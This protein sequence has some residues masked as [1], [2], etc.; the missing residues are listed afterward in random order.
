M[1]KI[2]ISATVQRVKRKQI[3]EY[4]QNLHTIS[5]NDKIQN[6]SNTTT[7]ISGVHSFSHKFLNDNHRL[8]VKKQ[9]TNAWLDEKGLTNDYH[10]SLK[11]K[12]KKNCSIQRILVAT[13]LTV[14]IC[15][16]IT[17]VL[18]YIL[19]KS[20]KQTKPAS[21]F[22]PIL[23]WNS[24]GITVAGI[25]NTPGNASNL[26][27][28]PT[29]IVLIHPNLLYI[30]DY[31]NH[32]IQKYQLGNSNGTTVAD[33]AYGS[34]GSLSNQLKNPSCIHIDSSN[35]IYISDS[36]NNRVQYWGNNMLTGITVAGN[37]A[38]MSDS[39]NDT[40][41]DPVGL[42]RNETTG[43][44]YI[45]D[46]GNNRVM[47]YLL[48]ASSG[49]LAA[50]T[51][52]FGTGPTRDRRD[53]RFVPSR[54]RT[55]RDEKFKT[56]RGTGQS[57]I[58]TCPAI[59]LF[60]CLNIDMDNDIIFVD[61]NQN[62]SFSTDIHTSTENSPSTSSRNSL[63]IL[64]WS[65]SNQSNEYTC[66]KIEML[67]K[68]NGKQYIVVDNTKVHSSKC[69]DLFGFPAI[70]ESDGETPKII[71]KFVTCR[72]CYMTY[73]FNSNST[74]LLNNHICK[75]PHRARSSSASMAPNSS[76]S[77]H[78]TTLASYTAA[79]GVKLSD[80]HMKR[81]KDLQANWI[82][83]DIRPFAIIEDDGFREIA[84]E[85]VSLGAKYGNIEVGRVLR[86]SKIIG[87]H[88]QELAQSHREK[89]RL[90]FVEPVEKQSLVICPD[91][92]S[93]AH[94]QISY[95]G[96]TASFV[97]SD[98]ELRTIDLCCSP[99]RETN[100]TAESIIH[101]L[102]YALAPFGLD[103]LHLLTFVSDRGSNFVKA[104]KPYRSFFCLAHRLNN[105]LKRA[106]YQNNL[107]KNK[108]NSNVSNQVNQSVVGE[109]SDG[110][111]SDDDD[112]E[113]SYSK[114]ADEGIPED[115]LNVLKTII[116]C[117][118]LNGINQ[119]IKEAGGYALKQST[120][121]RWLSLIELLES[122]EKSSNIIGRVLLGKKKFNIN[123]DIVR[124]LVRL[125]RPFKFIIQII[126][127]GCEPSFHCVLISL[128][129]LR[130]SLESM[131]SLIAYEKSHN[132]NGGDSDED[133][134]DFES[135]GMLFFRTR[136]N[137]LLETMIELK[138]E[139]FAAAMLHPRYRHLKACTSQEIKKCKEYI[140]KEM[141]SV[142]YQMKNDS[143][144][145]S[146]STNDPKLP[147]KKK[148]KRFGHQFESGNISDE[149][150]DREEE[151]RLDKYLSMRLDLEKIQDDPLIFWKQH[152]K[153]FPTLSV[154]ARRLHS[155]P[156][157]TAS[158]ERSFS[159]GGQI[160]NERRTNLSPSQVDNIL[161]IRSILSNGYHVMN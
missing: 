22:I 48:N 11:K 96:I 67:M 1:K 153:T 99:Y 104:L 115:A 139:H 142:S 25:V 61:N 102:R 105:I 72:Q 156:A 34:G 42:T 24:T 157:T 29:D 150:D 137:H 3:V 41:N 145:S 125:L 44:L 79:G 74:R 107:N 38:G 148:Q 129:T 19:F 120:N 149:Y 18:F 7:T 30:A 6:T 70:I 43:T 35:G 76:S 112:D 116:E 64:S 85:L 126:Q 90:Q 94:R 12:M 63:S 86:S 66:K 87:L 9:S 45:A 53:E 154:L 158:V 77:C 109:E 128:L 108:Y 81:M 140:Q 47:S 75:K 4:N 132:V 134:D 82:C 21:D 10:K 91:L 5:T 59:N 88:I 68:Q 28:Q 110:D 136:I 46:F 33:E 122:I 147:P 100:K 130:A 89:V 27:N 97:T 146:T 60:N 54:P 119:K 13:L 161:F 135:D 138:V 23:R 159:G 8:V 131:S 83:K 106:F 80:G 32:R 57:F 14:L 15:I 55:G 93:D 71:E 17:V 16:V 2:S 69:W 26:L 49:T 36:G 98:Y 111:G 127:K 118:N 123:M 155:I 31:G 84:Q 117:K 78:Q 124:S 73:S 56:R 103:N 141:R 65:P 52:T 113:S 114:A 152:D 39:T 37:S 143:S 51:G 62:S 40:F 121:V 95:L 151:E 160:V 133:D 144:I 20:K 92:W 58:S 101:A 50:G